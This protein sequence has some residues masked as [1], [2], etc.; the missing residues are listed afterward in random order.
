M[1][2]SGSEPVPPPSASVAWGC[3][4]ADEQR[5]QLSDYLAT[6]AAMTAVQEAAAR[7]V[8]LLRLAPG[9][10]VLD[11]GCGTGVSLPALAAAVAPGG[12]VTG[13]DHAEALLD[14][15]RTRVE[16][17]GLAEV[18][19]LERGDALA[20][21]YA[22]GTFDAAHVSRVL[23]HLDDP[24]RAL[25]E[26]RRV[27]KPGGWVVAIEP[28]FGGLRIDHVDPEAAR[29]IVDGVCATI[30]QPAMGLEL[31][32]RMAE[33]GFVERAVSCATEFDAYG[34]ELIDHYRP[35]AEWAVRVGRLTPERAHAAV[36]YLI[37]A[38][39][40]NTY[41]SYSSLFVASA[42]VPA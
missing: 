28:D 10:R 32:R 26:L 12:S 3:E 33:A 7:A 15:A 38:G 25:H 16:C 9:D 18:V 23:I 35:A 27:V 6:A 34:P 40:T 30:R 17:L 42:R 39:A 8:D 29:C 1:A 36:E 24:D 31:F 13:L 4:A 41:S 2:E 5:A 11:V 37:A 19:R 20:L 22:D 21:P 14:E